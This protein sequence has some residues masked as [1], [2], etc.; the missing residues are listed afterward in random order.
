M[1]EQFLHLQQ[2]HTLGNAMEGEKFV[3]TKSHVFQRSRYYLRVKDLTQFQQMQT[4]LQEKKS[5][6]DKIVD[7]YNTLKV[8]FDYSDVI[9]GKVTFL[10]RN[11][12]LLGVTDVIDNDTDSKFV[13]LNPAGQKFFE[14][15]CNSSE[16]IGIP[17]R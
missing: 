12:L 4:Q 15:V 3:K 11:E 17:L 10:I 5:E 16:V 13:L 9:M 1:D 6:M 14:A 8:F 2:L 7:I